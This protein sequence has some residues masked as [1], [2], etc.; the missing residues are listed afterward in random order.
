MAIQD[1]SLSPVLATAVTVLV[2]A[3]GCGGQPACGASLTPHIDSISPTSAPRFTQA[4]QLEVRGTGFDSTSRVF[5][6]EGTPLP[7]TLVNPT[8]LQATITF[9]KLQ[10][11]RAVVIQVLNPAQGSATCSTGPPGALSNKVTFTVTP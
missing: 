3:A 7:T 11:Q 6:D 8:L 5:W 10:V 4:V 9:E 1:L 2:L